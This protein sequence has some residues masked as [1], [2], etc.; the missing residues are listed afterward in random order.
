MEAKTYDWSKLPKPVHH[1]ILLPDHVDKK[2]KIP[3]TLWNT[4]EQKENRHKSVLAMEMVLALPDDKV[5]SLQDRIHLARSYVQAHFITKGLAAQIDIHPP[6][7][8][9]IPNEDFSQTQSKDHNWHAHVLVTIRRFKE[10]GQELSKHKARDLMPNLRNGKVISGPNWGKLR[11]QHQNIFFEQ[12][13]LP[14]RVDHQSIIPQKHLGPVRMRGR[15]FHLLHEN[16]QLIE[17]IS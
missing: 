2:F 8:K 5:I 1:E 13:G 14:L 3:T 16:T 17:L 10:N 4:V 9:T 15:A 6:E 11:T 12:K 7:T